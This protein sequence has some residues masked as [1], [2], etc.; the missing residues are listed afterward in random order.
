MVKSIKNIKISDNLINH[1]KEIVKDITYNDEIFNG[2]EELTF[3]FDNEKIAGIKS[4][5]VEEHNDDG[6][7]MER[8]FH[9]L[10]LDCDP[11]HVL[12]FETSYGN[13]K[14]IKPQKNMIISFDSLKS[15]ALI[16][17]ENDDFSKEIIPLVAFSIDTTKN[18]NDIQNK[19]QN[20]INKMEKNINNIKGE[21]MYPLYSLKP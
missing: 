6:S 9:L 13:M 8:Y 1:I 20:I 4:H 17:E 18:N 15:H 14:K 10:I 2:V 3:L 16:L 7:G 19:Y 5:Y 12:E 21:N 11:N